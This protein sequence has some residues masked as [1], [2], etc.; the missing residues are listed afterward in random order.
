ME[1]LESTIVLRM[2]V[3]W[4]ARKEPHLRKVAWP[5]IIGRPEMSFKSDRMSLRR[6]KSRHGNTLQPWIR[7]SARSE[8]V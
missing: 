7:L 4:E 6:R 3:D 2:S 1:M 8:P 5:G